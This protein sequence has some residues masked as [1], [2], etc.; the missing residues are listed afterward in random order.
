MVERKQR[1]AAQGADV[2]IGLNVGT[3]PCSISIDGDNG[4]QAGVD[5]LDDKRLFDPK[6]LTNRKY[7]DPLLPLNQSIPVR[8]YVLANAIVVTCGD[9]EV[10]RWHGD[11]RRLSALAAFNPPN[12]TDVDRMHLWLGAW[13]S[14]F[15]FRNL[16][17]KSLSDTDANQLSKS[18][19]G[20]F[21]TT[22]QSE[23]PLRPIIPGSWIPLIPD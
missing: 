13:G 17:L 5:L 7:K 15:A 8:C 14:Q 10:V 12:A 21:P 3:H 6:N 20:I 1:N 2:L 23:V 19:S 22:S 9:K 16:E 18:F 4:R 11:P